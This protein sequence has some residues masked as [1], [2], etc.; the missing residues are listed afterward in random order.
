MYTYDCAD[1]RLDHLSPET[2]TFDK[3]SCMHEKFEG[4]WQGKM[5]KRRKPTGVTSVGPTDSLL[6]HI[7]KV[8]DPGDQ[9][10]KGNTRTKRDVW[11]C[12]PGGGFVFLPIWT[13]VIV[14]YDPSLL[15]VIGLAKVDII[16]SGGCSTFFGF[17]GV[18]QEDEF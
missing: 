6:G 7:D 10:C 13:V 9:G 11:M 17:V 5:S 15:G 16:V 14:S 2:K 18:L 12:W 4:M 8:K 1:T 3:Q